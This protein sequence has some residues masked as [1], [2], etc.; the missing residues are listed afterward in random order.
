M[1]FFDVIIQVLRKFVS[2]VGELLD[3]ICEECL[4]LLAVNVAVI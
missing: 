1:S 3:A 2:S 4:W